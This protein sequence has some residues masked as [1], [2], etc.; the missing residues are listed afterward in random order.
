VVPPTSEIQQYFFTGSIT[1]TSAYD[2]NFESLDPNSSGH[3]GISYPGLFQGPAPGQNQLTYTDPILGPSSGGL[4]PQPLFGTCNFGGGVSS[5]CLRAGET[6]TGA[7]ASV[8]I[9]SDTLPGI[10]AVTQDGAGN[11]ASIIF[12]GSYFR[13]SEEVFFPQTSPNLSVNVLPEN[14]VPEPEA[15]VLLVAGL[16]GVVLLGRKRTR[17]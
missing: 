13:G 17:S 8:I 4:L 11:P 1:N 2:L 10:Y 12:H 3:L 14:A 5:T 7:I 9:G 6:F 15:W 16:A